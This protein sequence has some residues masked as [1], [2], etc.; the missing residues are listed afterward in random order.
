MNR[1]H[2]IR[3]CS[4]S[5]WLPWFEFQKQV[6]MCMQEVRWREQLWGVGAAGLGSRRTNCMHYC[7]HRGLSR[8]HRNS[9]GCSFRAVRTFVPFSSPITGYGCLR[10][11]E[12][13]EVIL[14]EAAL[15][16]WGSWEQ[17]LPAQLGA[18]SSQELW[19]WADHLKE[20]SEQWLTAAKNL[21]FKCT[22]KNSNLRVCENNM[23]TCDPAEI[24][25]IQAKYIQRH[26][27]GPN[28]CN[29]ASWPQLSVCHN[30]SLQSFK[31]KL[32]QTGKIGLPL[33]YG[34]AQLVTVI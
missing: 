20:G 18:L 28:L 32:L 13:N 9:Q 1:R 6:E 17:L 34:N 4:L 8:S 19:E 21:K 3:C 12:R 23:Q 29:Q 10:E 11:K 22:L 33:N 7:C 25:L 24:F 15:F 30:L 16:C 14:V 31:T 27:L 5:K 2:G 26:W